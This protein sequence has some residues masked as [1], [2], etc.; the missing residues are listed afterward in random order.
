MNTYICKCGRIVQKSTNADNTRNR[1]T[2]DCTGCPYLLPYGEQEYIQ[3]EGFHLNVKGYECRMSPI[4]N[5]AS[6][7]NGLTDDKC[8]CS[9]SSLDYDFLQQISSWIHQTYP[10][11]EL[12][13]G[14][15]RESIR[16]TDF[17]NNGRY[18]YSISCAQNKKGMAAKAALLERFFNPDKSRKDLT[19]EEE[20]KK[21]KDLIE[22]GKRAAQAEQTPAAPE[23]TH[24]PAECQCVTCTCTGCHEACFGHCQG[25]GNPTSD[26]NNYQTGGEKF[27]P[28]VPVT[29]DEAIDRPEPPDKSAAGEALATVADAPPAF[30]YSGLD[31]QAR[32]SLH[33]A[34]TMIKEARRT[35]ISEVADA[36]A[37]A[38]EALVTNC[39]KRKGNNQYSE[40]TFVNWC[41][42]VGFN[43]MAAYRLLNVSALFKGSTPVERQ[44]LE[45]AQPSLLYAAAKPS[46]PAEAVAAVKSGD[47][48]TYKEYQDLMQQLKAEQAAREAAEAEN[49]ANSAL[50]AEE[51]RRREDSEAA[52]HSAERNAE[53]AKRLYRLAED[54]RNAMQG[55]LQTARTRS[56][57]LESERDEARAE[58]SALQ[59]RPIEVAVAEPDPA[60][61]ERLA[62]E[63]AESIA[64]QRTA[65][66]EA[67]MRGMQQDLNDLRD[68]AYQ[69]QA[70]GVDTIFAFAVNAA[71]TI[72][73]LR[74][75]F[76]ELA[77]DL[78]EDDFFSALQPMV[79]A[80]WKISDI[81]SEFENPETVDSVFDER[82]VAQA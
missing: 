46:A 44:V 57:V 52:R 17:S 61:I 76:L 4:L 63:K 15:S 71:V 59:S 6:R 12:S 10:N 66:L 79:D 56:E 8:T 55:M 48:T 73:T 72:D 41:A 34:E 1:D 35:F 77:K 21:I 22:N 5:Y 82:E 49:R 14:F 23:K 64:A 58:L 39:D 11:G 80:A 60:E 75:T 67:Q 3:G 27:L 45:Q 81:H 9:V 50:L 33:V 18:R 47:I 16:P 29:L 13:G 19:P 37:I 28:E 24:A 69:A 78:Q 53:D 43:R 30:D 7:F 65:L 74:S 31:A 25:C 38:H 2:K 68:S 36:V 62:T 32:D 42:S 51:Q 54:N 40:S 70:S 20:E 26:C